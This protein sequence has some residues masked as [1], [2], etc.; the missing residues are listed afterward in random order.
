METECFT[1][2]ILVSKFQNFESHCS[3]AV[4]PKLSKD[5]VAKT[6]SQISS[7]GS[8]DARPL[9]MIKPPSSSSN[10]VRPPPFTNVIPAAGLGQIAKLWGEFKM[11]FVARVSRATL[12]SVVFAKGTRALHMLRPRGSTLTVSREARGGLWPRSSP[13]IC[14]ATS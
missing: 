8:G 6:H 1:V 10:R 13:R 3:E 7:R 14:M 9:Q 2:P 4:P 5:V 12:H 11:K